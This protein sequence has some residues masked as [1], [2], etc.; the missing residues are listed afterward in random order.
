M[1]QWVSEFEKDLA[2]SSELLLFIYLPTIVFPDL[3]TGLASQEELNKY[4]LLNE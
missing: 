3:G 1:N 2:L 4:L